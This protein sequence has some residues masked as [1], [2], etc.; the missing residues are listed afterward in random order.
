MTRRQLFLA[1]ALVPALAL[2]DDPPTAPAPS[3]AAAPTVAPAPAPAE[4]P[5]AVV[6]TESLPVPPPPPPAVAPYPKLGFALGVGVP[7]AATL[8]VLYR[9]L[10]WLRLSAGPSWAYVGWGL[11]GGVVLSPIRWAISPT[12]GLEAGRFFRVDA[13]KYFTS[14]DPG[15]KPL[16]SQVQLEYLAATIGLEFGSQR[17]F[18]FSLRAGL[19]WLQVDARGTGTFAS[20][21]GTPGASDAVVTVTDPAIRG[22]TPTVQLAFQYFL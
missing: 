14:A 12:I 5:P 7:H 9:P 15:M 21:G 1:C 8:D 4:V 16:L 3:E 11:H 17:G 19:A 6:A 10:P 20:N 22:S 2:A 18:S 13:N